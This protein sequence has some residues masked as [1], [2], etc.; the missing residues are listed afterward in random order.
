MVTVI[1]TI[2]IFMVMITFHELGH[3]IS[4]KLLG[5]A[6]PEFSVGMG[7]AILKHQGKKTL[8]ALRLLPIGGYCRL[9]GEDEKSDDPAAF[10]NQKL[11][12]RFI[13]VASGAIINLL[14]GFV[15]FMVVVKMMS[16][17]PTNV[18]ET[19]DERSYLAEAGVMPGDRIVSIDGHKIGIFYD[20]GLYTSELNEK[21]ESVEIVVKRDGERLTFNVKPSLD[22]YKI[23]YGAENAEV[24]DSLNGITIT[25]TKKYVKEVP[26][27][28]IGTSESRKRYILGFSPRFEDIT[29]S[30]VVHE[31]WH[32]TRFTMVSIFGAIRD[33]ISGKTGLENLSGPVGVAGVI[34]DAV[35]SGEEGFL[36]ILLI[37]ATLTINLG[38][39]NLLPLPALDGGRL[40]F[41]L[42]ELLRGKPVPPEKEGLVHTI[43]LILLLLLAAV[44]C[45]S[46]IIKLFVK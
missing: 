15:L 38:I 7:P 6:V 17:I 18:I 36:N 14:M 3:F 22:E 13:I 33:M 21:T 39:F 5:V 9:E 2:V 27:E 46:D 4:A 43:G 25:D 23:T 29:V 40:F 31:A 35:K 42:I 45:Y 26:P 20:I 37:V 32:Y 34:D 8:Y 11:W 19:V 44:V 28:I 30:N 24:S 10:T 41:M 12:K 16:P 1:V